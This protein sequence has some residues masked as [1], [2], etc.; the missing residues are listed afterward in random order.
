[1]DEH[2][3][4]PGFSARQGEQEVHG[5]ERW[6]GGTPRPLG[7]LQ[8]PAASVEAKGS[9]LP[10]GH[11]GLYISRGYVNVQPQ[12]GS[13]IRR[14]RLSVERILQSLSALRAERKITS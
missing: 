12:P 4:L 14:R 8:P 13:L 1:M 11:T 2:A 10:Q 7:F 5:V 6:A 9:L 3:L